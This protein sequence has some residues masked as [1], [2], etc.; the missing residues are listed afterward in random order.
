ML[1]ATILAWLISLPWTAHDRATETPDQRH[2]RMAIIAEAVAKVAKGDRQKAAF[3]LSYYRHE[4]DFDDAVQRCECTR[5]R[6]DP[7]RL[8]DGSIEFRA[9]GLAQA[10]RAP[11]WDI[12]THWAFCGTNL[13]SQLVNARFVA[14]FYSADNMACGYARLAGIAVGCK[15][16]QSDARAAA[17]NRLMG[18]L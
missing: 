1:K 4:T 10:H 14:R 11:T 16:R 9:H 15:T 13:E 2:D 6:C 3:V 7:I 12:A 18:R 8:R 17:A 5:W